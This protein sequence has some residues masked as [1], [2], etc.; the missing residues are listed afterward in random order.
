MIIL[1]DMEKVCDLCGKD[2]GKFVT[3]TIYQKCIQDTY[4]ETFDELNDNINW[5]EIK[6]V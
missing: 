3:I 5:D 2:K 4:L 6:K 1:N